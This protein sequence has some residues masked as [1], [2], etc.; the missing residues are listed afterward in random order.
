[1]YQSRNG[2]FLK[3]ARIDEPSV[4]SLVSAIIELVREEYVFPEVASEICN[5]LSSKLA[6]EKYFRAV[7]HADLAEMLTVDLRSVNGDKHLLV[8]LIPRNRLSDED[9]EA[10]RR[11]PLLRAHNFGFE[12]VRVMRGNIGYLQIT[13]FIDTIFEGAGDAA[14]AAF[15]LLANVDGLVIDLR[16]NGGGETS[17]IQ[18]VSTY[19]LAGK[20]VHLNSFYFRGSDSCEQFW[21]LP[22]V[23]GKRLPH[24]PVF[25][26]CSSV[27][28]SGAEEF[29]YNLQALGRATIVGGV[30]GGGAHPAESYPISSTLQAFVPHGRAINPIT[31]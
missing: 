1:M 8:S 18:L 26:L 9:A 3:M 7:S 10:A 5:L 15:S 20:P 12:E 23:P 16:Q 4:K 28:F 21:T 2:A 6:D 17:M 27:T 25:V 31:N 24:V 13:A 30:T 22:Y 29:C 19:L 11:L 14:A